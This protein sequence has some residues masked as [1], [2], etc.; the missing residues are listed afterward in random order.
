M[1]FL[2]AGA[3]TCCP[4]HYCIYDSGIFFTEGET[5][6]KRSL[7]AVMAALASGSALAAYPEKPITMIIPFPPGQA[8]DTFARALAD[9]LGKAVGQPVITENKAGAGSNIGM[10]QAVRAKPDG[11]TIVVGGS[12]AAVNQTLYTNPGYSLQGDLKAVSGVFSVPLIFLANPKSGIHSLQDVVDKSRAEP[13][14]LAYASAGIGGTQHLS[15]EMFQA[16]THISL[17][18]IPYKGS[19]PAQ[20]DFIGNQVPLMVD[21]VT[22]ALPYIKDKKA[23]PL[24]VTTATRLK[25]LPDV[26]TVGEMVPGFEAIGWA[27]VFVPRQT[28]AAVVE[29]LNS[30]IVKALNGPK[31]SAFIADRGA[32]PMP[33]TTQQADDF[34]K[35]EVAKW[36]KAVKDS[37]AT[38]D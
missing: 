15:A 1:K 16:G 3:C 33:Q 31:L 19:G 8:T 32:I 36:G 35:A 20:T 25:A 5:E 37:G 22:A 30:E 26:P 34:M 17:R 7:L 6:L 38:V 14:S 13:E 18:H 24:G 10:Q 27:A 28:P 12:A 2:V 4:G 23:V 21:S 9:E 29:K 11:Y